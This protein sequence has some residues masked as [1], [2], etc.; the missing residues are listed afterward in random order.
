ME[1]MEGFAEIAGIELARIDSEMRL[2]QLRR[3][4]LCSDA[5]YRIGN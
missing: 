2:E 5:A 4:L 3:E 1:H